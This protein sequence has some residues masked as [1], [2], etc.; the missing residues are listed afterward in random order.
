[1]LKF[2]YCGYGF[3]SRCSHFVFEFGMELSNILYLS[4]RNFKNVIIRMVRSDIRFA[5]RRIVWRH[6]ICFYFIMKTVVIGRYRNGMAGRK[7]FQEFFFA[8]IGGL[9]F[10]C[11][12]IRLDIVVSAEVYRI[13]FNIY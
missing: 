5:S 9:R 8:I 7:N 12:Y 4:I 2:S 10:C 1:M 3:R 6:L 11:L 13:K